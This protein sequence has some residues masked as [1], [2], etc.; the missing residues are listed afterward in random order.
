MI[1]VKFKKDCGKLVS[2]QVNGHSGFDEY[3]RDIVCSAVSA[4]T[5]AIING[6]TDV[7]NINAEFEVKDGYSRL[8]LENQTPE[9]ID[10]CQVLMETML[11]AIK[12][13]EIEYG[14]YV[15]LNMEEV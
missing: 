12:S 3:N 9:D 1:K 2:F 13:M 15:N 5:Y 8:S 6:I 4:V 10:K 14:K 7:I 11:L